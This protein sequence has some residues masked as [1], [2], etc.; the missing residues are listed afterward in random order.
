MAE[1]SVD[2]ASLGITPPGGNHTSLESI[3]DRLQTH[4]ES[5]GIEPTTENNEQLDIM[6]D[7]SEV[8][9]Q[10]AKEVLTR[11][12]EAQELHV[13]STFLNELKTKSMVGGSGTD[14][15][16]AL[17]TE[18]LITLAESLG[19]NK[20]S[21]EKLLVGDNESENNP[22]LIIELRKMWQTP[23]TGEKGVDRQ[24]LDQNQRSLLV[25]RR[26]AQ[27]CTE[28]FA[29]N[30]NL[31][32][33]LSAEK[34]IPLQTSRGEIM[35]SAQDLLAQKMDEFPARLAAIQESIVQATL[36]KP[37]LA[38]YDAHLWA[39]DVQR[40]YIE[41]G[42][43]IFPTPSTEHTRKQIDKAHSK[44][45][46][47]LK[48]ILFGEAG[49]GKTQLILAD[50][51][52]KGRETVVI[53]FHEFLTFDELIGHTADVIDIGGGSSV[54]RFDKAIT[55]FVETNQSEEDF[56]TDMTNMYDR[57]PALKNKYA[58]V[59][60]L[61]RDYGKGVN[62]DLTLEPEDNDDRTQIRGN[63]QARLKAIRDSALLGMKGE[64]EADL[65]ARWVQ[66]AVMKA[67]D[68]GK[69]VCFDE[70][71]KAGKYAI[72]GLLSF[73]SL[74]PGSKWDFQ[75][76]S[77]VIPE[78]FYICATSNKS[79]S[80][81]L[82]EDGKEGKMNRFLADRSEQIR[83]KPQP[84]KDGLMLASVHLSDNK[85]N[86]LLNQ[87]DQVYMVNTFSYILPRLQEA[88]LGMPVT[89]R[90][91][92]TICSRLVNYEKQPDG[93]THYYRVA[94]EGQPLSVAKAL[95]ESVLNMKEMSLSGGE[96]QI[97]EGILH[98]YQS[99]IGS[100]QI[101]EFGEDWIFDITDDTTGSDYLALRTDAIDSVWRQPLYRA[102]GGLTSTI[103]SMSP[104]EFELIGD[105]VI[106]SPDIESILQNIPTLESRRM[107][108]TNGIVIEPNAQGIDQVSRIEP[109]SQTD[110]GRHR[111][112]KGDYSG[113]QV[114]GADELGETLAV[115]KTGGEIQ[116]IFRGSGAEPITV[117]PESGKKPVMIDPK[118][119][120]IVWK[121]TDG[122]TETEL[123]SNPSPKTPPTAPPVPIRHTLGGP[124]S[125]I[126]DITPD[127]RRMLV[128]ETTGL[129][130][131][132]LNLG[133]NTTT[134]SNYDMPRVEWDRAR[135]IGD[136]LI[137]GVDSTGQVYRD[138]KGRKK[139][140][141]VTA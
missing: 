18:R 121:N 140:L 61:V 125:E 20:E 59:E 107:G 13:F 98:E 75:G 134:F 54:D 122:S 62:P 35:V 57:I 12:K 130:L 82:I 77:R 114:I 71:D 50:D 86:L 83:V 9:G 64:P 112:L 103:S 36:T 34:N 79:I 3:R 139:H 102:I 141:A 117:S 40:R 128:K 29:G 63:F 72:D 127:G 11:R 15:D 69:V 74:S 85:G 19:A 115:Q 95:Q 96:A 42:L 109:T 8:R 89:N 105:E 118:G 67:M 104:M 5:K 46:G 138:Q 7:A 65:Q 131:V 129:R 137:T 106:G 1:Q 37:E 56:W 39:R 133:E 90:V 47:L 132:T 87:E 110:I 100:G 23:A 30:T 45:N 4:W 17:F 97:V 66:G 91:I 43:R 2:S 120:Y 60:E 58:S 27:A 6:A 111:I 84:V 116:I 93:S 31:N 101:H 14:S 52:D 21:A 24:V 123:I 49:V 33:V 26:V 76:G 38:T 55:R 136:K 68:E 10:Y 92:N 51:A 135:F 99:L 113:A 28:L 81:S 70:L 73:L 53:N 44:R 22:G 94:S 78:D 16:V 124:T 108:L 32:L 48:Y 80:G 41:G 119:R 88:G 25:G 126:I